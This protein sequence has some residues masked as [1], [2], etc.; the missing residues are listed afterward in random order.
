MLPKIRYKITGTFAIGTFTKR[1]VQIVLK[2]RTDN[3]PKPYHLEKFLID[4]LKE[5]LDPNIGENIMT[6]KLH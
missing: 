4:K 1:Y 5:P 6:K 3:K 2:N